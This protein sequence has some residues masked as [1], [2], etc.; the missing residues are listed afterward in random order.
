MK[1]FSKPPAKKSASPDIRKS[2]ATKWQAQAEKR[3]VDEKVFL[4]MQDWAYSNNDVRHILSLP[5]REWLWE[6]S[7]TTA[8]PDLRVHFHGL[9]RDEKVW[10]TMSGMASK[11]DQISKLQRFSAIPIQ[12]DYASF[13]SATKQRFDMIYLDWKEPWSNS[14]RWQIESVLGRRLLKRGGL[15]RITTSLNEKATG[16]RSQS[17]LSPEVFGFQ[18]MSGGQASSPQWMTYGTTGKIMEIGSRMRKKLRIVSDLT[19]SCYNSPRKGVT[20]EQSLLFRVM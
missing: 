16:A 17:E 11:L 8:Y 4:A 5:G 7:F 20:R 12:R 13:L 1:H 9:E 14:T 2:N 18:D 15:L 10:R 3:A 6:R 19:I